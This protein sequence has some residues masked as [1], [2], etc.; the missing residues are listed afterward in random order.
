MNSRP[1]LQTIGVRD[2]ISEDRNTGKTSLIEIFTH[3]ASKTFP[4]HYPSLNI[5]FCITDAEGNYTFSLTLVHSDQ[6][7]QIAESTL[8]TVEIKDRVQIVDYG[9]IMLRIRFMMPVVAIFACLPTASLSA[10]KT[11]VVIQAKSPI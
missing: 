6:D 10:V 7:K 9:I 4:C 2:T 8:P 1:S 11:C 5:Y 3:L